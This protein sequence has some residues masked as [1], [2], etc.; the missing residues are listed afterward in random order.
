MTTQ[1]QA[2]SK[3]RVAPHFHNCCSPLAAS[4]QRTRHSLTSLCCACA[5]LGLESFV[6][7]IEGINTQQFATLRRVSEWHLHIKCSG[8]VWSDDDLVQFGGS[9]GCRRGSLL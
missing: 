4:S 1:T 9:L 6:E 8:S 2:F 5:D 3:R 7:Q